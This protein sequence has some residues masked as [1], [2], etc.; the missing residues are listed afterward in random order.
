MSGI[1]A[2]YWIVKHGN[3]YK[4]HIKIITAAPNKCSKTTRLVNFS[5]ESAAFTASQLAADFTACPVFGTA[6]YILRCRNEIIEKDVQL[7][8]TLTSSQLSGLT[9]VLPGE[10]MRR[11]NERVRM[12]LEGSTGSGWRTATFKRRHT[13]VVR[14]TLL[15]GDAAKLPA[16]TEPAAA[17]G[18]AAAAAAAG[19]VP[20]GPPAAEHE[21]PA[22]AAAA[23]PDVQHEGINL[24]AHFA[25][26]AEAA[27]MAAASLPEM[28]IVTAQPAAAE[29]VLQMVA[30]V[31][32]TGGMKRSAG[33][34]AADGDASAAA[35]AADG[36]RARRDEPV[37]GDD[38]DADDDAVEGA[39][40]GALAAAAAGDALKSGSAKR[41]HSS[42]SSS[43]SSGVSDSS[44]DA[45]AAA[46]SGQAPVKKLCVSSAEEESNEQVLV[47]SALACI[48]LQAR[49]S[50]V[51]GCCQYK[52]CTACL[53]AR[54]VVR[55]RSA[56]LRLTAHYR[57]Y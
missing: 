56:R 52:Q 6:S 18:A 49:C 8:I 51:I 22:P 1:P 20:G 9:W 29:P 15:T 7:Y 14:P 48:L 54:S 55:L 44:E 16:S 41:S 43:D 27:P 5:Y 50:N 34:A 4:L 39:V 25:A 31:A 45:D 32:A 37:A 40:E 46:A 38:D 21:A 42:S 19:P 13:G 17:G 10:P 3:R 11:Y 47:A 35:A 28:D 30:E 33:R 2:H 23:A 26:S 53:L 24:P 36:K 57:H 12:K